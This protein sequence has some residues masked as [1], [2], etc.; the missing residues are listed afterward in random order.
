MRLYASK[1]PAIV[2]S[3]L[4]TLVD[5]GDIEVSNRVEFQTDIESVLRE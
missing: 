3:V 4:H 2:D 5:S 1:I